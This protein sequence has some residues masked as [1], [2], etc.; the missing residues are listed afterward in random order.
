M[1]ALQPNATYSGETIYGKIRRRAL[2]AASGGGNPRLID[3]TTRAYKTLPSAQ[4]P[5]ITN[6][7][8]ATLAAAQAAGWA[9]T[10]FLNG[11]AAANGNPNTSSAISLNPNFY[12]QGGTPYCGA[13]NLTVVKSY[14]IPG[15]VYGTNTFRVSAIAYDAKIIIWLRGSGFYR[16]LVN[17]QYIGTQFTATPSGTNVWYVLDFTSIGGRAPRDMTRRIMHQCRNGFGVTG[18]GALYA[19]DRAHDFRSARRQP[20]DGHQRRI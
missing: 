6:P 4:Q 9:V 2:I 19:K 16:F 8:Y 12:V 10:S 5:T 20:R 15:P 7:S 17:D 3:P 1:S 18:T 14:T 11:G 13:A